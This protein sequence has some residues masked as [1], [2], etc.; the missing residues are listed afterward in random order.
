M[1]NKRSNR[2]ESS[3]NQKTL[4]CDKC[5]ISGDG[6]ET[7]QFCSLE[8]LNKHKIT[9]HKMVQC[10][11]CSR[12]FIGMGYLENHQKR[13]HSAESADSSKLLAE[14]TKAKAKLAAIPKE[15][16]QPTC[17]YCQATFETKSQLTRHHFDAHP[18]EMYNCEKCS[19]KF[20]TL[21]NLYF[22]K[23][24]V[25]NESDN[26][27]K[28]PLCNYSKNFL[29]TN[30]SIIILFYWLLWNS[31]FTFR[32]LVKLGNRRFRQVHQHRLKIH[33]ERIRF[34]CETCGDS[35]ANER[36]LKY[37]NV[38]KHGVKSDINLNCT[39]CGKIFTSPIYLKRHY[40]TVHLGQWRYKCPQCD[41]GCMSQKQVDVHVNS[42]HK[43]ILPHECTVEGCEKKY[44][45]EHQLKEHARRVH[46]PKSFKCSYCD[47]GMWGIVQFTPTFLTD[48]PSYFLD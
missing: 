14:A 11:K 37:H 18:N 32:F 38:C 27:Y 26:P 15:K 13:Y 8:D 42:V 12:V 20:E 5:P 34:V 39:A 16:I 3:S 19:E 47:Y 43:R 40:N 24:A 35:F 36:Y 21:S 17:K 41:V 45:T 44:A 23:T 2:S 6:S 10:K 46:G 33:E 25:H 31:I 1:K 4:Q 22:H 28:C 30:Q 29:T 7:N 48:Y 9:A